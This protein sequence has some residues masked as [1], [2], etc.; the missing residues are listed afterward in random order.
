MMIDINNSK[1]LPA[2]DVEALAANRGMS[3]ASFATKPK[4]LF[5]SRSWE[6]YYQS[7]LVDP[8]GYYRDSF[9]GRS[10]F[11]YIQTHP[12]MDH[13]SGL[14][15]FFWQGKVPIENF[16][17][18]SHNKKQDK[19][20]FEHC[21]Y[22]Y[23]DWLTYKA[24]RGGRGPND[25]KHKVITNLRNASGQYWTDDRVEV[26]SPTEE[27]ITACNASDNYNDCSYVLKVTYAGR[28]IILPGD[29]EIPAWTSM[30]D[31]FSASDLK[32]DVL[33]ASHH[34]RDSGYHEEAV[35]VMS[36]DI[37]VCSVG[38]KPETDASQKYANQGAQVL[39]T[40]YN[41]TI[42]VSIKAN[43]KVIVR[44]HSQQEIAKLARLS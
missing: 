43:G 7:L 23:D 29:A 28:T 22:S 11:R 18:V 8:Y 25:S 15:R 19:A 26:L 41:G 20:D 6:E 13:M 39:S 9:G 14:H 1:S 40:R 30:L 35:K 4:G 34:G 5:E 32:C 21:P 10:I 27:I 12:D 24:L 33:K 17:D 31:A 3:L 38:K 44:D 2:Q 36:P 42:T 37:V 16:W